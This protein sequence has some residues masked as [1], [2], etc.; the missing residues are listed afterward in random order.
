MTED[1]NIDTKY[2]VGGGNL[3]QRNKSFI[4]WFSSLVTGNL[5]GIGVRNLALGA[6]RGVGLKFR[7][8]LVL[9]A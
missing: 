5:G 4:L 8:P 9:F 2:I 3:L 1:L 7:R 6:D